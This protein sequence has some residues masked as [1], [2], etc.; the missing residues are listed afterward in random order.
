MN[1][2]QLSKEKWKKTKYFDEQQLYMQINNI[3]TFK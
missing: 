1:A 2:L 3:I